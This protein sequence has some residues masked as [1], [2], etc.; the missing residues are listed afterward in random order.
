MTEWGDEP[1]TEKQ[2]KYLTKLGKEYSPSSQK[3]MLPSSLMKP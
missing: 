3:E 2:K 1:A